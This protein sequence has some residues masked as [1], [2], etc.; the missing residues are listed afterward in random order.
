ME[1]FFLLVVT[2]GAIFWFFV[3]PFVILV[4]ISNIANVIQD[5]KYLVLK[6]KTTEP[7]P[8]EVIVKPAPAKTQPAPKEKQTIRKETQPAPEKTQSP[9]EEKQ[10]SRANEKAELPNDAEKPSSPDEPTV[11]EVF[12]SRIGDWLAV[13]GAY[14]PKGVTREFAVMTSWLIRIGAVIL[15]GAMVYFLMMMIDQGW[16]GPAQRV[17]GM[18]AGGM[19]GIA[20]GMWIKLKKERYAVLGEV[21]TALG[22][23]ALYL[24]FGLG[25]RLYDPPVI[26]SSEVA[27]VGLV[28][29]TVVAGSLSVYN[30][31]L[32][33]AVLGLIGALMVPMI[34]H[35]NRLDA[36][37]LVVTIGACIV[38]HLRQWSAFAFA[39][40][41]TAFAI[42][43]FSWSGEEWIAKWIFHSTLYLLALAVTLGGARS[44]SRAAN[45]LCWTF[46]ASA[47]L[48]WTTTMRN[49]YFLT[50]DSASAGACLAIM[51]YI[52][53]VLAETCRH[54]KW[55]VGDGVIFLLYISFGLASYALLCFLD[56]HEQWRLM[57]FCLFA[58]VLAEFHAQTKDR[59]FGVLALLV[60]GVCAIC[61]LTALKP[62]YLVLVR[63][64]YWA[65][66]GMRVLQ[67]WCVPALAAHLGCRLRDDVLGEDFH[68]RTTFFAISV[69]TTF[70]L[71]TFESAWFGKLFLPALGGGTITIAWAMVACGL[72]AVGIMCRLHL[73]RIFGILF[74]AGAVMKLLAFDTSSLT[75]IGRFGVFAIVGITLIA[76]AFLYLKY[77][78]RFQENE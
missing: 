9:P 69:I 27:F 6:R 59:T 70:G 2:L 46:V 41:A 49:L 13:R 76:T 64:G 56:G 22:T 54:C 48:V 42:V 78:S 16:I 68:P 4:K 52:H 34:V 37:L 63:D 31:S 17:Y 47:A 32:T 24:S 8:Q 38:A 74:L 20:M 50:M 75:V 67:L 66:L 73:S 65:S 77:K 26:E 39:A 33:I 55:H 21:C 60:A 5:L 57:G 7:K 44:R 19:V 12:W 25:H 36:Y 51:T 45:D 35:V 53:A 71:L 29:A 14:A 58:A 10:P 61:F 72:L 62:S 30:R 3:L 15:V 11:S 1:K 23:V 28:A 43:Q 18:M 40:I